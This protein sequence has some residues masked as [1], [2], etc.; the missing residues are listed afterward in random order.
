MILTPDGRQ[1]HATRREGRPEEALALAEDAAAELL[2]KAGP[3]FFRALCLMRLLV[4]RPEPDA[5]KLRAAL[6]EHGHRGDR[7]AAAQRLVR[8]RR[9]HRPRRRAGADR[10]QPQ[11]AA[12]LEIAPAA[13]RG[14]QAAAVRRRRG[15]GGRGARAGLRDGRDG[16]RHGAGARRAHRLGGRSP[17]PDCCCI[18][19]ATGWP[20]ISGASSE[21]HGF[22]VLQPVGLPHA[23]PQRRC[24]RIRVEQLAMGEIEGVI[25]M[26]PH[27]ATI[28]AALMR[29]QG[30]GLRWPAGSSISASP[31]R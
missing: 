1:C 17:R 14:A 13:R 29:K 11:R 3:D 20:A 27:T 10:H 25:L 31:R 12:R 4:T 2:A 18:S 19:P 5:L 28:Y 7:R 21:L 6:E 15:D 23:A 24:P 8:G 16:S 22:R 9:R 26:S 30:L